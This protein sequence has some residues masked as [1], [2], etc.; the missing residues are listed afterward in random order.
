MPQ[1]IRR[2]VRHQPVPPSR[3]PSLRPDA[4]TRGY[5]HTWGELS[6]A[7]LAEHPVCQICGQTTA[8]LVHHVRPVRQCPELRLDWS[9]LQGVC[10]RCHADLHRTH[11]GRPGGH[12]QRQHPNG[13]HT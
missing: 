2:F 13:E 12:P 6:S 5:D 9:N 1:S 8:A 7:Y 4:A 11:R 10:R 3:R